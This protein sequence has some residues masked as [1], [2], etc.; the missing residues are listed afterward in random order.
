M[1]S[2][3]SKRNCVLFFDNNNQAGF[4]V[5]QAFFM[6]SKVH[7]YYVEYRD[8]FQ[9]CRIELQFQFA[10]RFDLKSFYFIFFFIDSLL[11]QLNVSVCK[12][13]YHVILTTRIVFEDINMRKCSLCDSD[14]WMHREKTRN[15][16]S[17]PFFF[18]PMK[19][20]QNTSNRTIDDRVER[21]WL[22]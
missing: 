12:Y 14:D 3:W 17:L 4:L 19:Y 16:H 22:L 7:V 20:T 15:K 8:V 2:I 6:R 10:G 18:K 21:Q 13:Q 1:F 11:M 9:I 5:L